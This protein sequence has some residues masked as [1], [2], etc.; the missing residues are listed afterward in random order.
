MPDSLEICAHKSCGKPIDSAAKPNSEYILFG[1]EYF[2]RSCYLE[3]I[4]GVA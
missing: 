1:F 3:M 4:G 2:H